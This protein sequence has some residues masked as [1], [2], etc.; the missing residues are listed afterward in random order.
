MNKSFP[1]VA[2]IGVLQGGVGNC[3]FCAV[4]FVLWVLGLCYHPAWYT[5]GNLLSCY[6]S[7]FLC[8]QTD[9]FL[10]CFSVVSPS[11]FENVSTKWCPEIK[12]HAPDAVVLL[13][14]KLFK[15]YILVTLVPYYS[16]FVW[17]RR[18]DMLFAR[19]ST[20]AGERLLPNTLLER[21]CK[22]LKHDLVH[23]QQALPII[24]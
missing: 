22:D 19:T 6:E 12:H 10:I 1:I 11:S 2:V 7:I 5:T 4:A 3:T 13:I 16:A 23:Q 9:V 15:I 17:C 18:H 21:W 20:T 8:L 14:G 24:C